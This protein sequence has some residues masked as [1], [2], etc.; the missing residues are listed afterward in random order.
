M[1]DL[2]TEFK[3]V[4]LPPA[5]PDYVFRF[6][7]AQQ[8]SQVSPNQMLTESLPDSLTSHEPTYKYR[9]LQQSSPDMVN[10]HD[11]Q[12]LK[13]T[14]DRDN[15][16]VVNGTVSSE[17][18][19]TKLSG[20][21]ANQ[22][23]SSSPIST[24]SGETSHGKG[25]INSDA[26]NID[27]NFDLLSGIPTSTLIPSHNEDQKSLEDRIHLLHQHDADRD[28][29]ILSLHKHNLKLRAEVRDLRL[30]ITRVA[31]DNA[32]LNRFLSS[33]HDSTKSLEP[34]EST[35]AR[36]EAAERSL[37]E[38]RQAM[39]QHPFV[40]ILVEGSGYQFSHLLYHAY[41]GGIFAARGLKAEVETYLSRL[42]QV[43]D[44][45][46]VVRIYVDL[47]QKW[48]EAEN[49]KDMAPD[50]P[51]R[52]AQGFSEAFP[53]FDMIDTGPTGGASHDKVAT[54][55]QLAVGNRQCRH[56]LFGCT[57]DQRFVE[58]LR[59][60]ADNPVT[61][62]CVTLINSGN[63][64]GFLPSQT[65]PFE[66][67][68]LRS[69][70]QYAGPAEDGRSPKIQKYLSSA[71]DEPANNEG[72]GRASTTQEWTSYAGSTPSQVARRRSDSEDRNLQAKYSSWEENTRVILLNVDDQRIDKIL[73]QCEPQAL[74][75]MKKLDEK[76][77]FCGYY[78][79][80]GDCA[81]EDCKY[82]HG[83]PL[84]EEELLVL[85]HWMRRLPCT[86]RMACRKPTCI[87]GHICA[88]LP[89]CPHGRSCNFRKTHDVDPTAVK[90]WR[91]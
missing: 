88:N 40:Y 44:W 22:D 50:T 42:D 65:M 80:L 3:G 48:M 68:N 66:V 70:F 58:V 12:Q 14:P 69:V 38:A 17:E 46:F 29:L 6:G 10:I 26:L 54:L 78:H 53:C 84:K 15:E 73:P 91:S 18:Q 31:A 1:E 19:Y 62:A 34:I 4:S 9:F 49:T 20:N 28:S 79:L 72:Y 36:A 7:G 82:R 85:R 13:S 43:E 77:H 33:G 2:L 51:Q 83:Q 35:S 87:Y 25:V 55:F 90:V 41:E 5:S 16:F 61:S 60:Y 76:K 45:T 64:N 59:P 11:G 39:A 56:V 63:P 67:I 86:L 75:R 32:K 57:H 21:E 24:V 8:L 71:F 27:S 52:F 74:A 30:E 23:A 37:W 47:N 89:D 81:G